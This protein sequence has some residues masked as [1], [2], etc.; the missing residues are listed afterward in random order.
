M[1]SFS[2]F[3]PH[4]FVFFGGIV[5]TICFIFLLGLPLHLLFLPLLRF[6]YC[7]LSIVLDFL[8]YLSALLFFTYLLF[9]SLEMTA[10]SLLSP[11]PFHTACSIHNPR[12]Q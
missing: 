3:S 8:L 7:N 9:D 1:P 4:L 6:L 12:A 10:F 5:A 2:L 11:L